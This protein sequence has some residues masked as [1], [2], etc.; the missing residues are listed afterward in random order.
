MAVREISSVR[1]Q[2]RRGYTLAEL[3]LL[4]TLAAI[5]VAIFL[6]F[7][8]QFSVYGR[9]IMSI[10]VSSDGKRIA[11]TM[12]DGSARVWE[13][14]GGGPVGSVAPAG[15]A[16]D[17]VVA[18]SPD[19]SL[20]ARLSGDTTVTLEVCDLKSGKVLVQRHPNGGGGVAFSPDGKR[21]AVELNFT[22]PNSLR[23]I[24]LG[25]PAAPDAKPT[26]TKDTTIT[27]TILTT[28]SPDE[29]ALYLFKSN[30]DLVTWDMASGQ[31]TS[32][33]IVP[34]TQSGILYRSAA[35]SPTG[36]QMAV[37]R[38]EFN[39]LKVVNGAYVPTNTGPPSPVRWLVDVF[40][41]KS[42]G[43]RNQLLN[44][45]EPIESVVYVDSGKSLA[46]LYRDRVELWDPQTQTREKS[47]LFEQAFNH[48]AA[49]PDGRVVALA[50]QEAIY[51]LEGEKLR[52][53]VDLQPGS[54]KGALL[55]IAFA[56]VFMIWALMRRRRTVRTCP[57]CGKTLHQRKR[58]KTSDAEA[59]PD[60][61]M[62]TLSTEQ[63]AA[64][65]GK[66]G[67]RM[68]I[69]LVLVSAGI[70]VLLALGDWRADGSALNLL[71]SLGLLVGGVIGLVA[72]VVAVLIW[73]RRRAL[74]RLQ[75]EE[76]ALRQ[77]RRVAG[78]E[79]RV[80]R[81]REILLWTDAKTPESEA[82]L[83][84]A[85]LA[86]ELEDC[87]KRLEEILG[88][89]CQPQGRVQLY[90]YAK[91]AAAQRFSPLG[92]PNP[93]RPAV[94]CG[95]WAHVGYLWLDA[96]RGLLIPPEQ[97]L[98]ALLA[99]HLAGWPRGQA[100]FWLGFALANYVGRISGTLT[101]TL[102]QRER[103]QQQ[104]LG[105]DSWRRRVAL[106]AT[107]GTLM[108]L[109]DVF[110]RR[111]ISVS[112]V[113]IKRMLPE[114]YQGSMRVIQ[115]L[116]SL[117]DYLVGTDS[118]VDQRTQFQGLWQALGRTRSIDK[119]CLESFGHGVAELDRRWQF[120]ARTAD[121]GPPPLPPAD[122]AQAAQES[123][124]PLL[125]DASAPIQR[126]V[127][128]I[129]ILGGS[130]W[131]VGAEALV[132]MLSSSHEDLR[133]EALSALRLMFGRADIERADDW[134]GLVDGQRGQ[135]PVASGTAATA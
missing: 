11:A 93:D 38:D 80:E 52:K 106:W 55:F 63:L 67:R 41:P 39:A 74:V 24:N 91:I 108:P 113:G 4:V 43:S 6:D 18:I 26:P 14:E 102:S 49:S 5:L 120:W 23:I 116:L 12:A 42:P 51:L 82:S 96:A 104:G 19:G 66:Q 47:V 123:V 10:S 64:A 56:V 32:T 83:C 115:Q 15:S 79:G 94:Y 65:A 110:K 128:A 54:S 95:P 34:P 45:Q 125:T 103:E 132:E 28:F 36:D 134:R 3:M 81:S 121:F 117:I 127:R 1:Q 61:R 124:I 35:V 76:Y 130:G 75:D 129:R 30:G 90:V 105:P 73:A 126:R 112:A 71:A 89:K 9:W 57:Q 22:D 16:W 78:S 13:T 40:D 46:V 86:A 70:V 59:C 99:Y 29:R 33:S 58:K 98:R 48:M 21:L 37:V 133:R 69:A 72:L 25:D 107:E 68:Q 27:G 119:A 92:G 97:S 109:K 100:G 87:R 101:P 131:L 85:W 60:C 84:A 53:L 44:Q 77:A 31:V 7:R 135:M 114:H 2:H 118:T 62:E 88:T 122:I 20:V 111:T 17:S 50:E 8:R